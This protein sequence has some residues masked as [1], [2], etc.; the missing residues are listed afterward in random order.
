M[1]GDV[2][3]RQLR[4]AHPRRAKRQPV[5]RGSGPATRR[6]GATGD[7]QARHARYLALA[8]EASLCGDAVEAENCLQHAE[9]YF[10]VM[11]GQG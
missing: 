5:R 7:A 3:Q 1:R 9:H 8:R 4:N 10:R 6:Y 2:M 11:Q